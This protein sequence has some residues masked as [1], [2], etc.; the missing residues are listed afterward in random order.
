MKGQ[1]MKVNLNYILSGTITQE[2]TDPATREA[3]D[4][5]IEKFSKLDYGKVPP[6]DVEA[7][8]NDLRS[9]AGR[10]I[11]RY[12]GPNETDLYFIGYPREPEEG[13]NERW[14]DVFITYVSDY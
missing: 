3:I 4:K 14:I 5:S 13:Q 10:I 8:N 6:E 9:W 11:G 1:E 7:N 2:Q 12:S